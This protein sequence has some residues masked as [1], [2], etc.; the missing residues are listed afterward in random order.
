MEHKA[1]QDAVGP[2]MQRRVW[3]DKVKNTSVIVVDDRENVVGDG[4]AIKLSTGRGSFQATGNV[5]SIWSAPRTDVRVR[6]VSQHCRDD[7]WGD[8]DDDQLKKLQ[9][10]LEMLKE[11]SLH[12]RR[13]LL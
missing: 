1:V 11:K 4:T 5:G 13:S 7:G 2:P 10:L 12:G 8:V 3:P 9:S 6:S